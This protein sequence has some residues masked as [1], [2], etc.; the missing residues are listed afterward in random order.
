MLYRIYFDQSFSGGGHLTKEQM[1]EIAKACTEK[2]KSRPKGGS[3]CNYIL[4]RLYR[5]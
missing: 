1:I 5:F 4:L 2:N 3:C